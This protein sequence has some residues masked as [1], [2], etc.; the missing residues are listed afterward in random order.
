MKK[1]SFFSVLKLLKVKC[2][3]TKILL[4]KFDKTFFNC[5]YVHNISFL[6]ER[7]NDKKIL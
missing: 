1:I 3:A 6:E 4:S 7:T 5:I 2:K